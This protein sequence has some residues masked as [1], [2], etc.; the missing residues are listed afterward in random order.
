MGQ[1]TESDEINQLL[2]DNNIQQFYHFTDRS[3]IDSILR[4]GGLI[5]WKDCEEQGITIHCPGGESLSRSLD[6]RSGLEDYVRVSFVK[7]LPM[8]FI[9]KKEG[10]ISDP[11][12]LRI[13]REVATWTGTLYSDQNATKTGAHIGYNLSDL[14][15]VKF[16]VFRQSY[17]DLEDDKKHYYSAEVLVHHRIP[18]EYILNLPCISSLTADRKLVMIGDSVTITWDVK[19]ATRITLNGHEQN[20]NG[21]IEERITNNRQKYELTAYNEETDTSTSQSIEI[22]AIEQ[23]TFTVDK[24]KLTRGKKERARLSW[25][26]DNALTVNLVTDNGESQE[27]PANGS[28]EVSPDIST[29][30]TLKYCIGTTDENIKDE[31]VIKVYV[32]DALS[33][34]FSIDKKYSIP[35]APVMLTWNVEHSTSININGQ[36]VP[37]S[38]KAKLQLE[39]SAEYILTAQNELGTEER[40]VTVHMMPYPAFRQ[41][42]VPTQNISYRMD[43]QP[44][45]PSVQLVSLKEFSKKVDRKNEVYAQL[46]D[47]I[48]L[49]PAIKIPKTYRIFGYT[50]TIQHNNRHWF[51]L[52]GSLYQKIKQLTSK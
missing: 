30:Y 39:K 14:K 17:F 38:G 27:V 48:P 35:K 23:P 16:N 32:Y 4:N 19:H 10:R 6:S 1:K 26:V 11:V 20:G 8:L 9:A 13:D 43:I 18:T 37:T 28:R 41:I 21:Q 44:K 42:N 47:R 15:Y 29:T 24:D 34:T 12:I 5:S 25:N 36:Q 50:I 52:F 40:R 22:D 45:I 49:N 7:D 33:I 2:D 46:P 31:K 51:P 3:N